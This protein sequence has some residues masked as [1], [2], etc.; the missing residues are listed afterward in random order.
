MKGVG[1]LIE[2][3]A[4]KESYL[5]VPNPTDFEETKNSVSYQNKNAPKAYKT[6]NVSEAPD[7]TS[8]TSN[9]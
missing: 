1:R 5:N 7:D 3:F 8:P 9:L 6:T 2:V 4:L